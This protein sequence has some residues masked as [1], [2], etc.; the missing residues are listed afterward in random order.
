MQNT[1]EVRTAAQCAPRGAGKSRL[2]PIVDYELHGSTACRRQ[3][4][5]VSRFQKLSYLNSKSW[6]KTSVHQETDQVMRRIP[7]R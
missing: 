3:G 4:E 2:E 6:R 7:R 1:L 5:T